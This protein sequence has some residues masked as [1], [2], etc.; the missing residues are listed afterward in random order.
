MKIDTKILERPVI[1]ITGDDVLYVLEQRFPIVADK[2]PA[3]QFE[4]MLDF[5][6]HKVEFDWAEILYS[7]IQ[8]YLQE[9]EQEIQDLHLTCNSCGYKQK[10]YH[11]IKSVAYSNFDTYVS[12]IHYICRACQDNLEL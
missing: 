6:Y 7:Y 3:Q 5:L 8:I 2:L 11:T 9:K 12:D 10:D 4:K 1:E